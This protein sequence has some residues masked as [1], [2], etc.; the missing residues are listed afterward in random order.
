MIKK[1]ATITKEQAAFLD[2]NYINFSAF[3]RAKI[4]E[5]MGEKNGSRIN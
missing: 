2:D 4:Q 1:L 3:V 5:R